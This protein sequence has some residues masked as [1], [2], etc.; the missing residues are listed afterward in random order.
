M[1]TGMG[2]QSVE[3]MERVIAAMRR[4]IER[5]QVENENLKKQTGKSKPQNADLA[6][7]NR[8]LK[9]RRS[10]VNLTSIHPDGPF[11]LEFCKPILVFPYLLIFG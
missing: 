3:D 6:R 2:G 8:L 4:V 1:G 11:H 9:V 7:E 10:S 5:L